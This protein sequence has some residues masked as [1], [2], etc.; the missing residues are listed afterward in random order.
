M[1][2]IEG[3][4]LY[5]KKPLSWTSFDVVNKVRWKISQK[6]NKKRLKSDMPARWT[7]WP[8]E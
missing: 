8:P 6:L 4:I 5:V 1:D 7:R 2:F 3:E